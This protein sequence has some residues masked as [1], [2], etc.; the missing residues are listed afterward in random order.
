M[1]DAHD[2][3]LDCRAEFRKARND[4]FDGKTL[5]QWIQTL[6]ITLYKFLIH[7]GYA[8]TRARVLASKRPAPNDLDSEG[9][10]VIRRHRLK[11]CP[12]TLRGVCIVWAAH[13]SERQIG[14]AS[15]R[16]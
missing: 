12:R 1:K 8:G 5:L 4:L 14:R 11:S 6:Q 9:L 3:P 2:L 10:V 16:E 7:H 13:E 15:C